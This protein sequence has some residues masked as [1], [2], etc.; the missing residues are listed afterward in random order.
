M[1]LDDLVY[2]PQLRTKKEKVYLV[3]V[4]IFSVLIWGLLFFSIFR[5]L[6]YVNKE[7]DL[8]KQCYVRDVYNDVVTATDKRYLI[9]GEKCLTWS[10]L[11]QD[12][13]ET[14]ERAEKDVVEKVFT[15]LTTPIYILLFFVFTLVSHLLSL[16]LIR[17][18]SVKVSETQFPEFYEAL[19]RLSERLQL[20]TRPDM[21][22][23]NGNGVLNAFATRLVFRKVLVFY[24]DLAEALLIEKD[25]K[26]DQK[27]LEAVIGHEL[28]HHALKHTDLF[29][30][31]LTPGMVVPF[32]GKAFSRSREYSSDQ[33]M[34]SLIDDNEP[35]Q[36]ALVKLAA[37]RK[38]G[39]RVHIPSIAKQAQEERG[40][41]SWWAELLSTH[42]FLP[43]R[44]KAIEKE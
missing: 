30:W 9:V 27:Q 12:E 24:S 37:G 35:C 36:R 43:Q 34:R 39:Q 29:N 5:Q 38:L 20:K 11:K 21:F 6:A 40:F 7:K 19:V 13:R 41:F 18:N 14:L 42:P 4:T 23:I 1:P 25:G 8:T 32:L 33:V 10:D 26:L 17:M 22:I 2:A 44:I 16:A 15:S 28:G 3:L 31:L